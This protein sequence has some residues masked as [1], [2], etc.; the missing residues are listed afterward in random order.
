MKDSWGLVRQLEEENIQQPEEPRLLKIGE[1]ERLV[2][3]F[4]V[5]NEEKK[6][7]IHRVR[8]FCMILGSLLVWLGTLSFRSTGI[9][10]SHRFPTRF[11]SSYLSSLFIGQ[12]SSGNPSF[13]GVHKGKQLDSLSRGSP[14]STGKDRQRAYDRSVPTLTYGRIPL[15][16]SLW[17][18]GAHS[19]VPRKKKTSS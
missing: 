3:D 13:W 6:I 14:S 7:P 15:S 5:T 18:T 8:A 1:W 19:I 16:L 2:E 17:S 10:L 9:G 11:R 12:A 4:S